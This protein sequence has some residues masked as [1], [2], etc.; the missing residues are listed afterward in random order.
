MYIIVI[1]NMKCINI[2]IYIYI[3]WGE[4]LLL[5][6]GGILKKNQIFI[7]RGKSPITDPQMIICNN[8]FYIKYIYLKFCN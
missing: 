8:V 4:T 1:H 7:Y 2:Y 6:Y 3:Y 5:I